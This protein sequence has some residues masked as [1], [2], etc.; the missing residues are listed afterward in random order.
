MTQNLGLDDEYA[1]ARKLARNFGNMLELLKS[2]ARKQGIS[3]ERIAQHLD[4]SIEDVAEVEAPG[5]DPTLSMVQDYARATGAIVKI[6]VS[7]Y[8][9][10]PI[11]IAKVRNLPVRSSPRAEW[12]PASAEIR[13]LSIV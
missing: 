3:P 11:P 5:A 9:A 1:L 13:V 6:E 8:F 12:T 2:R 7:Q 4:W 10:N